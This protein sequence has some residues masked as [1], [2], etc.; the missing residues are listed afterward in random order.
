MHGKVSQPNLGS[1]LDSI[2]LQ[3]PNTHST[4]T[5]TSVDTDVM[6]LQVQILYCQMI[7]FI[8]FS[9]AA[10]IKTGWQSKDWRCIEPPHFQQM[11]GFNCGVL[12]CTVMFSCSVII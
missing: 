1:L 11:D 5:L 4:W 9:E 3:K 8:H 2:F 10:D 12:V 6:L 7:G